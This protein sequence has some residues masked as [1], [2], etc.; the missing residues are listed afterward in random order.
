MSPVRRFVSVARS[1]CTTLGKH[2][3]LRKFRLLK[4]TLRIS[5][6]HVDALNAWA[7]IYLCKISP[8]MVTEAEQTY[9]LALEAS[10][11]VWSGLEGLEKIPWGHIEYRPFLRCIHG[12]A[13]AR[14]V[15]RRYDKRH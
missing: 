13:T 15:A 1:L 12:L 7:Y 10:R 9:K 2:D 5:L 11:L 14:K 8:Q 4:Q 3:Y 6:F